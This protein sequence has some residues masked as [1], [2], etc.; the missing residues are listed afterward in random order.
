MKEVL[1][2]LPI[3]LAFSLIACQLTDFRVDTDEYCQIHENHTLCI[4]YVS[5]TSNTYPYFFLHYSFF[6]FKGNISEI[7]G[8]VSVRGL[9]AGE[10]ILALEVHNKLRAK[11]ANGLELR[12][13]PGPQPSASN[14]MQLVGF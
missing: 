6:F 7:C 8:K 5:I 1:F 4:H 2:L 10:K 13:N 14:M 11:L 9:E 3:F 12:G